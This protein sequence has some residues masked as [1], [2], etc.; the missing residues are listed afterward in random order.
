MAFDFL[1]LALV[2]FLLLFLPLAWFLVKE[3]GKNK[4]KDFFSRFGI[5]KPVFPYDLILGFKIF[6]IVFFISVVLSLIFYFFGLND[7]EKVASTMKAVSLQEKMVSVYLI[8]VRVFAEEFF[9]RAF[10]VPVLGVFGSSVVFSLL[11]FSYGSVAEVLG[12][13]VLGLVLGHY[14]SKERNILHVYF[15]HMFYNTFVLIIILR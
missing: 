1:R 2:D 6:L 10:L 9:F 12:A 11:H 14:Y 4:A 13:F 3:P 8:V 5:K 7:L 15:A